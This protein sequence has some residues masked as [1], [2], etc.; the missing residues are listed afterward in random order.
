MN[1]PS[2]QPHAAAVIEPLYLDDEHRQ[3]L[4]AIAALRTTS[5]DAVLH[6]LI[7]RGFAEVDRQARLQAAERIGRLTIETVSD[8]KTLARELDEVH[9]LPDLP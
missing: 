7:D 4:A 2:E 1:S 6:D 9:A 5:L 3:R 8:P